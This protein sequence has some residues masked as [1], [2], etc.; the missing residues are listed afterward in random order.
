MKNTFK[1]LLC[2]SLSLAM[3]A[4]SIVL[5]AAASA[6][7]FT[8][9]F[10][11]DTV[12]KEWKF[13]FGSADD[14]AE[15]YIG[16]TPDTN[17]VT[18]GEYGFLGIDEESYKLGNRLDGFGSQKGQI[19]QLQAGGLAGLNDAVGSVGEDLYG[20]AGD[21]YYPTRF[22]LK[23]DDET[24]YRVRAT[25]T[26][27]DASKDAEIS[28]YTERKHPI[29]TDTTVK[30][31]ET[32][33]VEFS[34]RPTPIYYEKSEPKGKIEDGMVNVCVVGENS[35]IASIEIQ[36]VQEYPVFWVLGDSTVTDGNCALP[37]FRLQNYT[38]VGTG[39]TKYLPKTVAMVNEGEGGL[40]A[41][42]N[43]HFN[44]VKD[45]IKQGDF[46]YVEYGHNHKSDGPEGY[47]KNL[48]KY[49]NACNEVGATLIIVSPIE[50]INT[51]TDGQ[52]QHSLRGFAEAGEEYVTQKVAAGYENIAYVDLN[53]YSLDF[54]NKITNDNGG[55]ATAIKFY[56]QT[57]KG[58]G[59][60]QTHPN[61][62][63]AENL[64][65]EFIKAAKAVTD[66]TQKIALAPIM[67][68]LTGETPN[69]VSADITSLGDPG[70][71]SAWPTYVIPTDNEYPV[72]INRLDFNENGEA[73]YAKVTVQDAKVS[74][75]AY[76]IIVIT[77]KDEDGNE[78]GKIYALD[79][80]D[81]STGKGAQ[82][83]TNF[84]KDITISETDTYTATVWQALDNGGD[85]G[86]TVD[87]ANIQ[88]SA[89]YIPTDTVEQYL[90]NED[91][92]TFENFTY[93]GQTY[94]GATSQLSGLNGWGQIG[95]AGI[96]SYLNKDNDINYV[97][98]VS[99][100]AKNGAANQGSFYYAKDLANAI[101]NTGR[102][103]I[104]ADVW[105]MS[106][107]G[108]SFNLV[109]GH[110]SNKL[111]GSESLPL[112]TVAENGVIDVNGTQAG[113]VSA[114]SFTNVQYILDMDMGTATVSVG[115]GNP[116]VV[117]LDNYQTTSINVTP[118]KLTQFM[119]GGNKVAFDNKIANLQVASLKDIKLPE[120]TAG[121]KASDDNMG[122]V[123]I[124]GVG[125]YLPE[126][127]K[128]DAS[129]LAEGDG[130]TLKYQNGKAVVSSDEALSAVL[131]ETSYNEDGTLKKVK[132]T[133]I[134]VAAGANTAVAAEEGSR[135]MLWNSLEGMV[136]LTNAI[137]AEEDWSEY[138]TYTAKINTAVTATATANSGYV[139]MGWKNEDGE[140]VSMD[141]PY[142]FRLRKNIKLIA[143][144]VKEPGVE[145][146]AD[147]SISPANASLKKQSGIST[148]ISVV[149]PVDAA[150]TPITNF[151]NTDFAWSCDDSG[152]T[153]D[154]N[155]VVTIGDNF[156]MGGNLTKDITIKASINGIEK[157]CTITIYSY[158]YYEDMAEGS[159]K[160]DGMFMTIAGKTAIVFP[161]SSQTK[162]Y[163]L[164][165]VIALD[166]PTTITYQNAWTN[167][168]TCG[169][170][171]TLNFLDSNGSTIFSMAYTWTTLQVNGTDLGNA[172]SKDAW[173]DVK[174]DINPETKVVTV[175][176]G[177]A[178]AETT[179]KDGAADIAGIQFAS[180]GSVP[181]P[182]ARALGISNITIVQ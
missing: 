181:E 77:V 82:E 95:S 116:V 67:D 20:N 56:F 4:G 143:N 137:A 179:L 177:D 88:Y 112:F 49:F 28:L 65:Y 79:Q 84:T 64:A 8:P 83:I 136:P 109:T 34:V 156:D 110:T 12:E 171:R 146:I 62:S 54:Y 124:T 117:N 175:T 32:K 57:G 17:Y 94:D 1:K 102:Y 178:T 165:D 163:T 36:K 125:E 152:V 108:M 128:T 174:V 157:S 159:T 120:Y 35:A 115:G 90:L 52:Y 60:D 151:A 180:A 140:I 99:D 53:Q 91:G 118:S 44:M 43:Y 78:K 92:D 63:G 166:K 19:I 100:G 103:V 182:S 127:G 16:V 70:K 22:A 154:S 89:E 18:N 135:I 106:G 38:G 173:T 3:A 9:I 47:I 33:T 98:L 133:P 39:L 113:T 122:T 24:Y 69:L 75:S 132:S 5:P 158:A 164:A 145:D 131:I 55:N 168:N 76:G 119:F 50:R 123:E 46:L 169:Q 147:Y 134:S 21:I 41:A 13:D 97:E 172:V 29:F 101:G 162:T 45:R 42:D 148:A 114:T 121:V 14:I 150:N 80:V 66:P 138:K 176:V 160:Y 96:T 93:Y 73:S 149:N 6:A 167:Q 81:N 85:I 111:G 23:A 58:Q 72:V 31:G 15:G 7:E 144:F 40:N 126:E 37:F 86:L 87:P 130:I 26:T 155:G 71:S 59:T 161:G 129:M 68:N 2:A 153:V 142:T 30:A 48:D 10:A 139:F 11:G 104:S 27:L 141:T 170:L 61:D 25:V 74:M 51:F 105:Y 107:G